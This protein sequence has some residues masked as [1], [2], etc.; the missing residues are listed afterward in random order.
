LYEVGLA[1]DTTDRS[2]EIAPHDMAEVDRHIYARAD[3]LFYQDDIPHV[4]DFKTGERSYDPATS[5][6]L[7]TLACGAHAMEPRPGPVRVSVVNVIKTGE[8]R[9][10]THEHE[11]A[12]LDDHWKRMRR[13]HLEVL[14]TRCELRDERLQP[15]FVPGDHCDHCRAE[16]A[17]MHKR[18]DDK[19]RK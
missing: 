6:Q 11:T 8:L 1:I 9:W 13:V 19:R 16:V 5:V 4:V 10:S 18:V 14:E 15:L 3:T 17:C 7:L 12:A 2:A